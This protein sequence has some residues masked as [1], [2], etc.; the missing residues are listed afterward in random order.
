MES[1]NNEWE[2]TTAEVGDIA[3]PVHFTGLV[4]DDM[5]RLIP[6]LAANDTADARRDMTLNVLAVQAQMTG[7][8][9]R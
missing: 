1:R 6:I 5:M 4:Q 2:F 8:L 3:P 9:L 7:L